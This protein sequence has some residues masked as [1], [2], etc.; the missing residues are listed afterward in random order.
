MAPT[1]RAIVVVEDEELLLDVLADVLDSMGHKGTY[2]RT[3]AEARQITALDVA[4]L[5]HSLPDGYGSD[6][7]PEFRMRFPQ[8][9]LILMSGHPLSS[10]PQEVRDQVDGVLIKPF[11]VDEFEEILNRNLL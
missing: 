11:T 3:C 4:F 7:L 2:V 1:D 8:A 9:R 6:L 5:D 10:F